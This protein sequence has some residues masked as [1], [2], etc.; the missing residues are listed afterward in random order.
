MVHWPRTTRYCVD[1]CAGIEGGDMHTGEM[2]CWVTGFWRIDCERGL[3][4]V[5]REAKGMGG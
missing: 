2:S 1:P 4:W 5:W 3:V